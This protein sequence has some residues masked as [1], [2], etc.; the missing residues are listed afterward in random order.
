MARI[1][2]PRAAKLLAELSRPYRVAHYDFPGRYV[3]H[4]EHFLQRSHTAAD[5]LP[6]YRLYV[7]HSANSLVGQYDQA[8]RTSNATVFTFA[9]NPTAVAHQQSGTPFS[10]SILC[11]L[12]LK[13]GR[14]IPCSTGSLIGSTRSMSRV[15][16]FFTGTGQR[17]PW[18]NCFRSP[19]SATAIR[20]SSLS[21]RPDT[22]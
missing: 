4:L 1:D 3:W 22:G 12:A 21:V 5:R 11:A 16:D 15:A 17:C 19:G 13:S 10:L 6:G 14:L 2:P 7:A 8:I 20:G 18:S 9:V